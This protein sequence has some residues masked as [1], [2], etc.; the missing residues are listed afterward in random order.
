MNSVVF[1]DIKK[2]FDTVDHK[3]LIDK[4]HFYGVAEQE[5]DFLIRSY[6]TDR[7]Q[8]CSVNQGRIQPKI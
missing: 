8:C 2:D 3:T 5:L 7:V 1:L 4:L 6:L